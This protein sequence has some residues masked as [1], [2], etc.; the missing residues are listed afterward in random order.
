MTHT[1]PEKFTFRESTR[2]HKRPPRFFVICSFCGAELQA[3]RN[4]DG[5]I[6]TF[7]TN[8]KRLSNPSRTIS[9]RLSHEDFTDWRS[10]SKEERAKVRNQF[11]KNIKSVLYY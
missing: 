10:L 7:S 8:S 5:T 1:H 4:I 2:K 6:R 9:L 3:V 11:V